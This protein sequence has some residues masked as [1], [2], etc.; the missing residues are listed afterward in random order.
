MAATWG[1]MGTLTGTTSESVTRVAHRWQY[2]PHAYSDLGAAQ[3]TVPQCHEAALADVQLMAIN[4]AAIAARQTGQATL[5][6]PTD[7]GEH[8]ITWL[9]ASPLPEPAAAAV[10]RLIQIMR[11]C[12][13]AAG[14]HLL[15]EPHA[16]RCIEFHEYAAN[17]TNEAGVHTGA[18]N[19]THYDAGSLLTLDLMLSHT[20]EFSGGSM[21]FPT[22]D[23]NE[24]QLPF[25][26]GDALVFVS[27]RFH[28]VAPVYSGTR[29]VLVI[30]LW[31]G[32]PRTC[33]HRC[34]NPL[35][36]C[37]FR[38]AEVEDDPSCALLPWVAEDEAAV[39]EEGGVQ[40]E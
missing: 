34:L 20:N 31:R 4:C 21:G 19:R 6:V 25:E 10:A 26:R 35:G 38:R 14:W 5:T 22:E 28:H 13:Q 29:S 18:P 23:G 27:H 24:L 36:A 37:A 3:A 2:A 1:K 40:G 7:G 16:V 12:D 9:Q 39:G 15:S 17:G 30:E 32:P 8:R 33:P 11:Q